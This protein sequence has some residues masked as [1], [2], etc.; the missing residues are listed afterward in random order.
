MSSAWPTQ[1]RIAR[2]ASS[3]STIL[4]PRTPQPLA[5]SRSPA[6]AAS[7]SLSVRPIRQAILVVPISST[8]NG[9]DRA[10]PRTRPVPC[11]PVGEGGSTR[12]DMSFIGRVLLKLASSAARARAAA[13]RRIGHVAAWG[14]ST[15]RSGRRRS[16]A[17]SG[18]SSSAVFALQLHQPIERRRL[19][20]LPAA[21]RRCRCSFAGST[22]VRRRAPRRRRASAARA[23]RSARR[24]ASRR[25]RA[26]R[27][28]RRAATGGRM[29]RPGSPPAGRRGRSARTFPG[30]ARWRTAGAPADSTTT[31]PGSRRSTVA[32]STQDRVSTRCRACSTEKPRIGS[33]LLTPSA[34]RSSG[35][36][37][38]ARPSITTSVTR[39]PAKPAAPPSRS[40]STPALPPGAA[41]CTAM[42]PSSSDQHAERQPAGRAQPALLPAQQQLPAGPAGRSPSCAGCAV[43]RGMP[44]S[45]PSRCRAGKN[46]CRDAR[47]VRAAA[48]SASDRAAC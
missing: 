14:R 20:A 13:C 38:L 47:P 48:R 43:I 30:S 40:R 46:S 17:S 45:P 12:R 18:R 29:R 1:A 36:G 44:R 9:P 24:S 16:I 34:A 37:V 35:S 25:R 27:G 10:V 5:A 31:V 28:R 26:R 11:G 39:S 4:P 42:T 15:S 8:P 33:P 3:R 6:R 41:E 2:S 7:P 22:A 23:G 21:S 32:C 19:H